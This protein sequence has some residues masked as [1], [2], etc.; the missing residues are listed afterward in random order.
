MYGLMLFLYL[1]VTIAANSPI[2]QPPN[3]SLD[4]SPNDVTTV[5]AKTTSLQIAP[6]VRRGRHKRRNRPNRMAASTATPHRQR[7]NL[8]QISVTVAQQFPN[9]IVFLSECNNRWRTEFKLNGR[10]LSFT[11]SFIPASI[12]LR[13][14]IIVLGHP[15]WAD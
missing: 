10:F 2:I 8:A 14:Y 15:L 3:V 7:R 4:L 1:G 6:L 12:G 13:A 5:R 9:R 11:E